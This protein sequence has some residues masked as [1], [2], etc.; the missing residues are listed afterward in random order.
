MTKQLTII[1]TNHGKAVSR[2]W[3]EGKRLIESGFVRGARYDREVVNIEGN[4]TIWLQISKDGKYKVAG[5]GDKPII[6]TSGKIIRD[7]FPDTGDDT[8][9]QVIEVTYGDGVI[10][11]QRA[12][13]EVVK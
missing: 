6:D 13:K 5:K 3:I 9:K 2:I 1:G 8:A 11:L 7:V 10:I 12:E 4:L